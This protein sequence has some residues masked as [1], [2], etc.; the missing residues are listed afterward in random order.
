M[1]QR[2][3]EKA[4]GTLH[5]GWTGLSAAGPQPTISSCLLNRGSFRQAQMRREE[6]ASGP[7]G[8]R[9]VCARVPSCV[10]SLVLSFLTAYECSACAQPRL[11]YAARCGKH[12]TDE[13][14]AQQCR[15]TRLFSECQR[16]HAMGPRGKPQASPEWLTG[17]GFCVIPA[18][19]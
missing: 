9:R 2:W 12:K 4:V 10:H 1:G 17:T 14:R 18:E 13:A 3:G 19:V 16:H 11:P 15:Q 6:P 7:T 8:T 5:P